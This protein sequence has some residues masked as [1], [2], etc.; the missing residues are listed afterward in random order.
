VNT[1]AMSDAAAAHYGA[2]MHP[3]MRI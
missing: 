3:T 1:P 2:I